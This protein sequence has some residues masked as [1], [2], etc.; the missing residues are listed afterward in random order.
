MSFIQSL[1]KKQIIIWF[2]NTKILEN[3]RPKWLI[4]L[5]I[6]LYLP[7]LNLAIEVNGLQHYIKTNNF[8][9]EE[10]QFEM[11]LIRDNVKSKILNNEK[12]KLISIK[13]G[14]TMF[15]ELSFKINY[16]FKNKPIVNK[17]ILKEAENH[18][19]VN[20]DV[21]FQSSILQEKRIDLLPEEHNVFNFLIKS[22]Q[23][24]QAYSFLKTNA[25]IVDKNSNTRLKKIYGY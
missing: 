13:Q 1:V 19:L 23:Y 10:W 20:R 7:E 24:N 4:G 14:A 3:Y 5:E 9:K 8:F 25:Y 2:P 17:E 12:I 21:Y 18:W 15:K 6:D 16:I 11:Q 22:K